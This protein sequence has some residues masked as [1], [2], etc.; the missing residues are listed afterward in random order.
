MCLAIGLLLTAT[1]ARAGDCVRVD[2]DRILARHLAAAG[3]RMEAIPPETFIGFSPKPGVAR[4]LT[5]EMIES[6]AARFGIKMSVPGPI[7]VE[8]QAAALEGAA[9]RKAMEGALARAGYSK[10]SLELLAY[11]QHALPEGE[12]EFGLAG[13]LGAPGRTGEMVWRGRLK[14]AGQQSVPV[15]ARVRLLV[16]TEELMT[17]REVGAGE[18]LAAGDVA[19]AARLSAPGP[20]QRTMRPAEAA[21]MQARRR[22][23]AGRAVLPGMLALPPEIRKGDAVVVTVSAGGASLGVNARAETMARKGQ[24]VVLTNPAS[25]K[26]F[27]ARATGRGL[28]VVDLEKTSHETDA[29]GGHGLP[30]GGDAGA[31]QA[32]RKE[33]AGGVG[34]GQNHR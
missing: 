22:I 26:K 10:Y 6:I 17:T 5:V 32:G 29:A 3:T 8:R 15:R 28:A 11:P 25:G 14:V 12:L 13:L 31:G 21:G 20:G 23:E 7:C 30:A 18:I 4:W 33:A 27:R 34:A 19:M 9:I 16:E 2:G 24:A 1:A